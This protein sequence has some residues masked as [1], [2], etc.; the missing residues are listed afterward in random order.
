MGPT[1]PWPDLD[2]SAP[3]RGVGKCH[4]RPGAWS[5]SSHPRD[6]ASWGQQG[7]WSHI[8]A[9][10]GVRQTGG[11]NM[12]AFYF[13]D[14]KNEIGLLR[15]P[16]GLRGKTL[17]SSGPSP[18]SSSPQDQPC[19]APSPH[20]LPFP[21]SVSPEPSTA[22]LLSSSRLVAPCRSAS[23]ET[24]PLLHVKSDVPHVSTSLDILCFPG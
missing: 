9:I 12:G 14:N 3:P 21:T 8:D 7:G 20:V 22:C 17:P 13:R 16:P 11:C 1:F 19:L 18:V 15:P 5:P 10:P 2:H 23:P 4:H 24:R 6:H